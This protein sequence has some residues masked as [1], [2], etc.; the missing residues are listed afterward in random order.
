MCD[1]AK[2]DKE[3]T[4]SLE[5][6]CRQG[7]NDVV[8]VGLLNNCFGFVLGY[9]AGISGLLGLAFT[10][11]IADLADGCKQAFPI[12]AF[13]P[14]ELQLGFITGN[15]TFAPTFF[16]EFTLGLSAGVGLPG[17]TTCTTTEL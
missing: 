6:F 7:T 11:T 16:L 15:E 3:C 1:I 17:Y 10:G 12:A 14:G 2:L 4:S 8:G 9:D 13:P 5:S